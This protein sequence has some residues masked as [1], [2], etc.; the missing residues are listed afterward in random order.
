MKVRWRKLLLIAVFWSLTE[1]Y[2]NLLGIDEIADYSEFFL[3]RRF[4][5]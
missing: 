2:F 5:I 4:P 1:I 3:I